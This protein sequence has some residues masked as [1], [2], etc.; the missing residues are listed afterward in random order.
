METNM[1]PATI[2]ATAIG[3]ALPYVADLGK[4]AAKS[5]AG[6]AGKSVWE[7]VKGK[8]ASDAGKEVVQDFESSPGDSDN[9]KAAEAALSKLLKSD[10]SA[11]ADLVSLLE[12]AGALSGGTVVLTA[13]HGAVISGGNMVGNT[14][15]TAASQ[16]ETRK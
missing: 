3:V 8:L 7:W 14:I 16:P 2:A 5:V 1:D 15:T 9:R 10:A 13:T 11:R 4:E 12:R 6:E